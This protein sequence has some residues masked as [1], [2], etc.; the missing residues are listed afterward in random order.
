MKFK[1]IHK[2]SVIQE[3]FLVFFNLLQGPDK[4]PSGAGSIGGDLAPSLGDG[5]KFRRPR[6]FNEVF[7]GNNLHFHAQNFWWPFLGHR[8]CFSDLLCVMSYMTLSSREKALFQKIIPW[9]H[10]FLL[11]LCL[12]M[13]STN[14][15]SQNMGGPSPQSSLGLR[16]WPDP[17]RGLCIP[18]TFNARNAKHTDCLWMCVLAN[19]KE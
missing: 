15:T 14:T 18:G 7:L 16:P 8:P 9:W 6:F 5:E 13:H 3:T 12:C 2:I 4:T 17:G 11:Y 1:F 10:L 19:F